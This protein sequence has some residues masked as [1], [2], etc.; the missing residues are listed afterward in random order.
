[1]EINIRNVNGA[2][3]RGAE[4]LH[5]FARQSFAIAAR[6]T[7]V[8][9]WPAPVITTYDRPTER[10]LFSAVRDANPFFHL[11]EAL[12]MLAGRNDVRFPAT[13][14]KH[15]ASFS[16]NGW[17]MQGAYGWRWRTA[18]GIDQIQAVVEVIKRDKNTRRGVIAMW[19][20]R[21]DLRTFGAQD[22]DGV[23]RQVGGIDSKDIPCN[24]IL[25]FK[26]R[27]GAL[28]MTICCRSNDMVWGAYGA[29]AVHFS[30]LQEYIAG[31]LG[32]EVGQMIQISDSFHVYT[33]G[34]SSK[35]WARVSGELDHGDPVSDDLYA[36]GGVAATPMCAG[37]TGWDD[38][39]AS[40]FEDFDE[41]G[42]RS[43][44]VDHYE[45]AWWQ[46]VAI[47]M[48]NAWLHRD[49]GFLEECHAS[50]WSRAGQLWLK[51]HPEAK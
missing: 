8:L 40:F 9:E 7:K 15:M 48:W 32:V 37:D 20:T 3:Q 45:T 49:E 18:F 10:V 17:L 39:L 11:F 36:K 43:Q 51:A 31:K 34:G 27:D 35:V 25:Y 26:L 22:P 41:H 6:G 1:M 33:E 42:P 14:V 13:I 5:I 47:P 16:D 29:N 4:L 30:M 21:H 38:D 19:D 50:D 12:W 28:R 2:F 24:S 23:V 44:T 46:E